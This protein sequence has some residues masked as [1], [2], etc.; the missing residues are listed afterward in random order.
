MLEF[1][2]HIPRYNFKTLNT[3]VNYLYQEKTTLKPTPKEN[4]ATKKTVSTESQSSKERIL[5]YYR[6]NLL[7]IYAS[8]IAYIYKENSITYVVNADGKR[9]VSNDSL[10]SLFAELDQHFFFRVN[11]QIIIRVSAIKKITK[12]GQSLKIET[13]HRSENPIFVGKNKT[14]AFKKWLNS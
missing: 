8:D 3:I 14:L 11:R 1:T 12:M 6:N 5:T 7:V 4:L 13:H 2:Y 9:S 10:D